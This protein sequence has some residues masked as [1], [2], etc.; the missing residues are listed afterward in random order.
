MKRYF[1]TFDY[2]ELIMEPMC[3]FIFQSLN[4]LASAKDNTALMIAA[5]CFS[6]ASICIRLI[7][8]ADLQSQIDI[9]IYY[10]ALFVALCIII[11]LI[12]LYSAI[13]VDASYMPKWALKLDKIITY[14]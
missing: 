9:C 7:K 4:A 1:E 11:I 2:L 13:F 12:I 6:F 5:P 14:T 10:I 3:F 8:T